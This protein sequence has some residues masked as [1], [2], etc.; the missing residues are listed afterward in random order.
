MTPRSGREVRIGKHECG[1]DVWLDETLVVCDFCC[2]HF[3]L[4]ADDDIMKLWEERQRLKT[5]SVCAVLAEL[6]NPQL[7]EY[8]EELERRV[9][10]AEKVNA[11]P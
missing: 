1:G 11:R 4:E 5:L 2:C 7:L 10:K 3:E 9:E 6:G 8:V